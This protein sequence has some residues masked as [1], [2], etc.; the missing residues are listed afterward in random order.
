MGYDKE[1]DEFFYYAHAKH[2]TSYHGTGDIFSSTCLGAMMRGFDW[3]QAA[4]IAAD[5]TA[6]CIALTIEEK[7]GPWYGVNFEQAIPALVKMLEK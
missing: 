3:K 7:K 2:S 6:L 4:T 1:K 5:Y